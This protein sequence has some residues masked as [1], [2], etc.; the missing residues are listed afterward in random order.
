MVDQ[1]LDPRPL[2]VEAEPTDDGCLLH[3][4]AT[5]YARDVFC[6]ADVVNPLASVNDGMVNLRAGRSV[7]IRVTSPA[8]DPQAF[9]AAVRCANTLLDPAERTFP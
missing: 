6:P 5:S 8:G 3:V 9:A 2:R 7:T 1:R 4:A